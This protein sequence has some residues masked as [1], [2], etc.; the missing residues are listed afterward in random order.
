MK[1]CPQC[2]SV[3]DDSLVYCTNDGS[4]LAPETFVMPS[5][6]ST[7]PIAD[8]TEEITVIHREPVNY[9]PITIDI[10]NPNPPP[11]PAEQLNYQTPP[12][13]HVIPVVI[14]KPRNTAKY[15]LFLVL[16]L[17]LGGGLVLAAILFSMFLSQRDAQQNTANTNRNSSL[18]TPTA[19]TPTPT[20]VTASAK[21]EKRTDQPDSDFNG[22]V[23]TLNAYVRSSPSKSAKEIDVLPIDDRLKIEERAG[24]SSPWFRVTCEHGTSGWMHGNTI[25]YTK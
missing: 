5:E 14:E 18:S 22:R 20:P 25:E 9:E 3:F 7:P 2:N 21:H 6:T 4:V 23:I 17:I 11:I 16:G 15:L 24:D 19:K 10:P 8:D 1:R 13:E 12:A